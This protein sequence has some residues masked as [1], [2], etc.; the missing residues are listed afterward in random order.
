VSKPDLASRKQAFCDLAD[1]F[2][3]LPGGLGTL[4]EAIDV[5]SWSSVGF[6]AKHVVFVDIAGFYS[7]FEHFLRQAI[8][9]GMVKADTMQALTVA[10]DVP[11]C[12]EVLSQILV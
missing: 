7:P 11:H 3:V 10:R 4:E 1:A 9:A 12:I 5:L 6:H 8:A 2:V